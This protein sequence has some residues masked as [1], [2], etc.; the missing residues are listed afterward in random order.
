MAAQDENDPM[1]PINFV[2]ESYHRLAGLS[3]PKDRV[4]PE[5]RQMGVGAEVKHA[6]IRRGEAERKGNTGNIFAV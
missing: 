5:Y 3:G 4:T 2:D 1:C 6:E